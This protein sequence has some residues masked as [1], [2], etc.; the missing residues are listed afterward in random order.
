MVKEQ[1]I[2]LLVLGAHGHRLLADLALGS[3]V[4]PVVHRL[5]IPV[6]VVPG[7]PP[8]QLA[9]ERSTTV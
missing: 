9:M 6:L 4:S 2:D 7:K 8:A 1:E 5:T 3:T